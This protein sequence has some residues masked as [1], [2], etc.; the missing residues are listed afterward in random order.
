MAKRH[1]THE[2]EFE[3]LKLVLDKFLWL[4]VGI[5]AFGFYQLITLTDNMTYGLLLLGAG[6]LLLI[7]FIAILMKEYNFLQ[8]PKN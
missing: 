7:V 5:M 6:A 3:I 1:M 4:G 8:S 2:E